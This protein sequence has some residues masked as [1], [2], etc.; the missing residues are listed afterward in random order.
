MWLFLAC[1]LV[2]SVSNA[3]EDKHGKVRVGLIILYK[4]S[5]KCRLLL[6][7]SFQ[8]ISTLND[9]N[10]MYIRP[11][12]EACRGGMHFIVCNMRYCSWY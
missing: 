5:D 10:Y 7:R 11:M 8:M 3:L 2:L 9:D 12:I 6:C 1:C 4:S